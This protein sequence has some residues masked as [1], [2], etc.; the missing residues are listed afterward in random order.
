[1]AIDRRADGNPKPPP[2]EVYLHCV[3][4]V[5][6]CIPH[7]ALAASSKTCGLATA[8]DGSEDHLVHYTK[9]NGGIQSG[10]SALE[11]VR[12]LDGAA[13]GETLLLVDEDA[14]LLDVSNSD[15]REYSDSDVSTGSESSS[16][17]GSS[18]GTN[19]QAGTSKAGDP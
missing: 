19:L 17:A 14:A 15:S 8:T 16:E 11:E 1:M 9:P 4:E 13:L 18:Q 6:K 5:W 3:V 10:R 7:E 2:H 12:I